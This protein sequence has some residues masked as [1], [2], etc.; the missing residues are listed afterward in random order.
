MV[1]SPERDRWI[2]EGGPPNGEDISLFVLGTAVLRNRNRVLRWA[3]A[4][5]AIAALFTFLRPAKYSASASFAPQGSDANRSGLASIARQFGV[6]LPTSNQSVSPEFYASLLRTRVL[7]LPVTRDTFTVAELGGQRIAFVDLFELRGPSLAS[8][9][10]KALEL[11]KRMVVPSVTRATGVV[12][13]SVATKWRSVSLRIITHLIDG[14]NDFN[15]R[16]RRGQAA[17]ERKFVGDRLAEAT[18]ELRV[19][20]D[21]LETFLRG[22]RDFG[23][24]PQLTM[25]RERLQRE[26]IWRQQVFSSLMEAY[27]DARIREVRDTPVITVIEAP[28][29]ATDPVPSGR[30]LRLLAGLFLGGI[31]GTVLVL[32]SATV[33]RRRMEG[34]EDANEFFSALIE[35]KR[36]ASRPLRWLARRRRAIP[37]S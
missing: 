14:V 37:T 4:G 32:A 21:R 1:T 23:G 9:E 28:A 26:I 12:D 2:V 36:Q 3:L 13:V 5:L 16:T 11:L 29:A 35:A 24:S 27:Q 19:A 10:D 8:R 22:N 7:L 6:A 30:V 25:Q 31:V 33:S 17:A 15:E 20:E 18:A 34:N